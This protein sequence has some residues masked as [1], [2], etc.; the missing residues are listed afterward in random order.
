MEFIGGEILCGNDR[1]YTGGHER[2]RNGKS[3]SGRADRR[4]QLPDHLSSGGWKLYC[5][6]SCGREYR[7]MAGWQNIKT[8]SKW[9]TCTGFGTDQTGG[10]KG[11]FPVVKIKDM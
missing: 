2:D 6:K 8:A 4:S 10:G 9:R 11:T 3:K 7:A 1:H 5:G